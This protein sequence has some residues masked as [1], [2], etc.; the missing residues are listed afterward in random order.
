MEIDKGTEI[1]DTPC[2]PLSV[3]VQFSKADP[4]MF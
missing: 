3:V 4:N 1:Q 2:R